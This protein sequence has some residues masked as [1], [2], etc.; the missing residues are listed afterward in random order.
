F[1]IEQLELAGP[2]GHEKVNDVLGLGGKMRRPWRHRADQRGS[3]RRTRLVTR[4]ETAQRD[5]TQADGAILKE[6]PARL[7]LERMQRWHRG[8]SLVMNSSRFNKARATVVHAAPSARS[9]PWGSLAGARI[10]TS[11]GE[12]LNDSRC[13]FNN[14]PITSTSFD[15]A[16]LPRQ[17]RN[18]S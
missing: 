16:A 10:L 13:R 11:R 1:V 7:F 12:C 14:L 5:R 18:A 3:A 4:E 9:T 6:M 2:T 17:S 15:P 8:Y